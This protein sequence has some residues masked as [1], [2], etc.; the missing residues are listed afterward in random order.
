MV[1]QRDSFHEM[2]GLFAA[3]LERLPAPRVQMLHD[4]DIVGN[5]RGQMR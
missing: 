3:R 2:L 5:Q 1:W 4:F